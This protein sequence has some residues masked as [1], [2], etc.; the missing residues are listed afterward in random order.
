MLRRTIDIGH[1]TI[2]RFVAMQVSLLRPCVLFEGADNDIDQ[3]ATEPRQQFGLGATTELVE[4]LARLQ[5]CFLD[6]V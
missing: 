4:S 2:E 1:H 6:D 3:D 5:T